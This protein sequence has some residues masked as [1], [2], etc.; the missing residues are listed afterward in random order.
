M[1]QFLPVGEFKWDNN[2]TV[3]EI[4]KTRDNSDYGHEGVDFEYLG[5]LLI[6]HSDYPLVPETMIV[7]LPWISDYQHILVNELEGKFADC[8]RMV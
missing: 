3:D 8:V 1:N 2:K 4:L 7:P 6:A 5:N